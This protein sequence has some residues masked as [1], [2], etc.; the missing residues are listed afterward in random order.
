M[1][2]EL[3]LLKKRNFFASR[4]K[5]VKVRYTIQISYKRLCSCHHRGSL[6]GQCWR[7]LD[8]SVQ[9][10]SILKDLFL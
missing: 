6:L 1:Y 4:D 8:Y 3:Y 5:D 9:N 7:A 2:V 10:I